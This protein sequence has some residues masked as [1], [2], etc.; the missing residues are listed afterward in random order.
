MI[1]EQMLIG[2]F[3]DKR[4]LRAGGTLLFPAARQAKRMKGKKMEVL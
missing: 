4:R 1:A 3:K 2:I